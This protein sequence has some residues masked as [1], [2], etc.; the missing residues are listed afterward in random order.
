MG[1][2][3]FERCQTFARWRAFL[4]ELEKHLPWGPVTSRCCHPGEWKTW[5]LRGASGDT[6]RLLRPLLIIFFFFLDTGHGWLITGSEPQ[7]RGADSNLRLQP[8]L[9]LYLQSV[10]L[11]AECAETLLDY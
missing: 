5:L 9:N 6:S 11:S 2:G 1:Q 4:F 8:G 3:L 10:S 7:S